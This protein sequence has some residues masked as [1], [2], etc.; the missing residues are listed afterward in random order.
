MKNADYGGRERLG[1]L[2]N[3][4]IMKMFGN[5]LPANNYR[6]ED[7]FHFNGIPDVS[8]YNAEVRNFKN[9]DNTK[10]FLIQRMYFIPD[11]DEIVKSKD[12]GVN[13]EK[14]LKKLKGKDSRSNIEKN[15]K[16][17]K[18]MNKRK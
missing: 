7:L 10:E 12:V 17:V 15:M 14:S 13:I 2:S 6:S 5:P 18:R 8:K 3:D 1:R 11:G 16:R 9:K 4:E